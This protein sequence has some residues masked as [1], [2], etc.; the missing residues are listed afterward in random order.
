MVADMNKVEVGS[1][2]EAV[3]SV[4]ANTTDFH[5]S[6]KTEHRMRLEH[7]NEDTETAASPTP[8]ITPKLNPCAIIHQVKAGWNS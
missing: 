6:D 2:V 1:I 3:A 8:T 4:V 7:Y 5:N